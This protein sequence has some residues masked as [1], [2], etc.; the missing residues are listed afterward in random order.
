M[1]TTL[2]AAPHFATRSY[3]SFSLDLQFRDSNARHRPQAQKVR[4][5]DRAPELDRA[6]IDED[7]ERWDGLA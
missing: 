3:L 2:I 1:M 5:V 4:R 6:T 7:P